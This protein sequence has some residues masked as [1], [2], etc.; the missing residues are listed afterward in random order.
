MGKA[1]FCPLSPFLQDIPEP[2]VSC[3]LNSQ[4]PSP[5]N[6]KLSVVV[7]IHLVWEVALLGCVALLEEECHCGGG[8]RDLLLSHVGD[9]LLLAT[10][11]SRCRTLTA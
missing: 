1:K 11:Q 6:T 10:F 9:N 3:P 5:K 7:C 4:T 8:L 2:T